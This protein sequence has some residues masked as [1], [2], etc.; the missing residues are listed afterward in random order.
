MQEH[1]TFT[2]QQAETIGLNLTVRKVIPVSEIKMLEDASVQDLRELKYIK[3]YTNVFK[4]ELLVYFS[5]ASLF[6]YLGTSL[7]RGTLNR[8]T[9]VRLAAPGFLINIGNMYY[10]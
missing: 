9:A 8:N 5:F 3:N 6:L 4:L 10:R 1:D 7:P 2:E